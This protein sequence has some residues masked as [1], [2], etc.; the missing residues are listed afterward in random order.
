[1]N[2]LI[3]SQ[4]TYS[5][6]EMEENEVDAQTGGEIFAIALLSFLVT[7]VFTVSGW[8]AIL[9][10]TGKTEGGGPIGL[11]FNLFEQQYLGRY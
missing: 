2:A 11:M 10:L 1:M 7:S 8:S 9:L 5:I 4:Q 3:N 6:L